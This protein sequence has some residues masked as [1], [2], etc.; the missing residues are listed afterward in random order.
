[1]VFEASEWLIKLKGLEHMYCMHETFI[2][3]MN[4]AALPTLP[5]T[6]S[7]DLSGSSITGPVSCFLNYLSARVLLGMLWVGLLSVAGEFLPHQRNKNE[8][9]IKN[10]LYSYN[11]CI[12]QQKSN[13][14]KPWFL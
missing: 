10:S 5:S 7:H 14:K 3:S 13:Q 6:A 2:I 8:F 1:M 12:I 4:T 11:L 9:L